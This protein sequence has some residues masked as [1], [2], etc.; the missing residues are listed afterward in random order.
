MDIQRSIGGDIIMAFDECPPGGS[1]YKYAKTSMEMTHRWL[2]RCF[3]QFDSTE[4]RYGY[5]Q[6]LFPI[7]Q[8]GTY[9]DLRKQSCEYI[10]SKDASGNAIG[11]EGREPWGGLRAMSPEGRQA[12]TS[13]CPQGDSNPRYRLEGPMS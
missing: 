2:D 8:G 9:K 7:V 4:A 12:E 5:T 11:G 13:W 10:A 6:N 1:E 3:K